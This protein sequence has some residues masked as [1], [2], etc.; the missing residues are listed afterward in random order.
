MAYFSDFDSFLF[1]QGTNYEVYKK[2]G[3]HIVEENGVWGTHFAVWAPNA[4]SVSVIT[5]KTGWEYEQWM[6][7]HDTG[8][9]ERFLPGV[10][11]GDAYRYVIVGADGVKRNKSDPYAFWSEKRPAN[12]SIVTHLHGYQWGDQE[13]QKQRLAHF[14]PCLRVDFRKDARNGFYKFIK[15]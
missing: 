3:A 10:G 4:Q 1:H 5:A 9:W 14:Q 8:V 11:D 6:E 2:L 7:G 15:F 12:A 13:H